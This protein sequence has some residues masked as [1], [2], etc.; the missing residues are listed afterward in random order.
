LDFGRDSAKR[1]VDLETMQEEFARKSDVYGSENIDAALLMGWLRG[2][3][4]MVETAT[5]PGTVIR[6]LY[7][8]ER[9]RNKLVSML[10]DGEGLGSGIKG[11]KTKRKNVLTGG[12]RRDGRRIEG[13]FDRARRYLDSQN[14][15]VGNS[16]TGQRNEA[17][18]A[19]GGLQRLAHLAKDAIFNAPKVADKAIDYSVNRLTRSGIFNNEVNRE[20]GNIMFSGGRDNL[21]KIVGELEN[22][23][24]GAKKASKLP[25]KSITSQGR[26]VP[27]G[28]VAA[29]A[30]L[31]LKK[32]ASNGLPIVIDRH[33]GLIGAA[34]GFSAAPD[35]NGDGRV[36]LP[37]RLSATTLGGIV[38]RG[39]KKGAQRLNKT[40]PAGMQQYEQARLQ[41]VMSRPDLKPGTPEYQ[42]AVLQQMKDSGYGG[43]QNKHL[44]AAL[45]EVDEAPKPPVA[46]ASSEEAFDS[47]VTDNKYLL[48]HTRTPEEKIEGLS[49]I[50]NTPIPGLSHEQ[51]YEMLRRSFDNY[52]AD[53]GEKSWYGGKSNTIFNPIMSKQEIADSILSQ[54]GARIEMLL[55]DFAWVLNGKDP[56]KIKP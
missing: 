50:V 17:V 38:G 34:A 48:A 29:S 44:R 9:Q 43:P 7:G 26:G 55:D 2:A 13:R 11:D 28:A 46:P 19:Q 31:P 1:N 40:R 53:M 5:N 23:Q 6:Q 42:S 12:V 52:I 33:G 3:E 35:V 22:F 51:R 47:V 15:I 30:N 25:M 37:E 14:E 56:K 21:R 16:Q 41:V 39:V 32:P 4:D 24:K 8:S 36:S 10:P 18:A 45:G 27:N 49:A 54:P 20:L